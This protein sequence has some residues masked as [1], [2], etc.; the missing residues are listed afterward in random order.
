MSEGKPPVKSDISP[1]Q[2]FFK[3]LKAYK[4]QFLYF[5]IA[6][7]IAVLAYGIYSIVSLH[8]SAPIAAQGSD[9]TKADLGTLGDLVGG[10]VNPV[11]AFFTVV[12]LIWSIQVQ[13]AELKETRKEIR[14]SSDALNL[15]NTMNDKNLKIQERIL[16][17]PLALETLKNQLPNAYMAFKEGV[18]ITYIH[19]NS[20]VS[21]RD[22]KVE[23][24][25][26]CLE[27]ANLLLKQNNSYDPFYL[28][29]HDFKESRNKAIRD[30]Y[31]KKISKLTAVLSEIVK[32]FTALDRVEADEFIYIEDAL[33]CKF[34]LMGLIQISEYLELSLRLNPL[35]RQLEKINKVVKKYKTVGVEHSYNLKPYTITYPNLD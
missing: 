35:S 12:L 14:R 9:Y 29:S 22:E 4:R 19:E 23:R 20:Q 16:I 15:S 6:V 7:V 28:Q 34:V 11:L 2:N 30:E 1:L 5:S 32:A 33:Q 25:K 27:L 31:N 10:I 8:I 17:V 26:S 18:Q 21:W 13:I 24:L 3:A